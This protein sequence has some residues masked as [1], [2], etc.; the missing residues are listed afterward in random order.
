MFPKPVDGVLNKLV[1]PNPDVV[2]PKEGVWPKAEFVC[3]IEGVEDW[4]R[5][6]CCVFPKFNPVLNADVVP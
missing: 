4:K 2:C 3:P 6:D 1:W 5:G